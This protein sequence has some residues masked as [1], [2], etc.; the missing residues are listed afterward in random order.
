MASEAL[1]ILCFGNPLHG[2]DG[3]G[4]EVCRRLAA[5]PPP[6]SLPRGV[7]AY[8]AGV[9]GL[10][11]AW[12]FAGCREVIVVDAMAPGESPGRLR[13]L[14]PADVPAEPAAAGGHGAGLGALLAAL[15]ELIGPPP[16]ITVLAAEAA[17][18]RP[19]SPGLSPPVAAAVDHAVARILKR[20][21]CLAAG[22]RD[23]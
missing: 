13:E 23:A 12:L 6:L 22:V 15:G 7:A 20:A 8:D 17:A 11:A 19:F 2:D 3:F 16:P 5:L 14:A 18:I 10:D 9:R 1:R 4:P 21:R